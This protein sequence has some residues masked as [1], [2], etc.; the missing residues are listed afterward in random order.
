[1]TDQPSGPL[2][3]VRV[4]DLTHVLNGPFCTMLLAHMG[5]EVL[6]LEYG[7]GDRFRHAWMPL[8]ADHDGYEFLVVNAN[9]R[10]FTLNLKAERGK[11]LF[12]ELVKRSDVVVENFSVG[13]MDRLG[14][15]YEA[16]RAV[17]PRI[18]YASSRGFG[19]F[20]PAASKR[21]NAQT[22]MASTGWTNATWEFSGSPGTVPQGI[23]DEAAGVSMALGIVAA[24]LSREQTGRGQRVDVAMQEAMLG[25][26]VSNFHTLFEGQGVGAASKPCLDGYVAFHLPDMSD[27]LWASLAT[28][29]GHPEALADAAFSSVSSRR[30]HYV[31]WEELV[32]SWV[33]SK[34]RSE[35]DE[36]FTAT[37]ISAASV[38]TLAE[39]V[40]DEHLHARAAFVQVEDPRAGVVKMLAPWIRFSET[41]AA[42]TGSAPAVGEHNR[43]V[44]GD[45]L[46]LSD[47]EIDALRDDGV[48]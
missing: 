47:A 43:S 4:L 46:G 2:H 16:L 20:G 18:V 28:A 6:K 1:M 41:P 15:S 24:L 9:K 26:M 17:N 13:V 14:L 29:L 40:D 39:V 11:E 12:L 35:L 42:I 31:Q 44:F 32:T 37:G 22:I 23:G 5:A 3:G 36:A 21:A 33:A 19:E 45:L 25:F 38:R 48:I 30:E 27:E 7:G 34:T 10:G 8:D